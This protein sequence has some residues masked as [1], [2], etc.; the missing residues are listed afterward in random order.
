MWEPNCNTTQLSNCVLNAHSAKCKSLH[1]RST[2]YNN[3]RS[4]FLYRLDVTIIS[5]PT[6]LLGSPSFNKPFCIL[7]SARDTSLVVCLLPIL[8]LAQKC[9]WEVTHPIFAPL[10]MHTNI[11]VR[12][13]GSLKK[14]QEG[15]SVETPA[16]PCCC[17]LIYRPAACNQRAIMPPTMQPT[18]IQCMFLSL[19][20]TTNYQV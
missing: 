8:S 13:H 6:L 10:A 12:A 16:A 1:L 18:R 9:A 5:H 7:V 11:T 19:W 17:S 20:S 14:Y 3:L 2:T 4:R 15:Y